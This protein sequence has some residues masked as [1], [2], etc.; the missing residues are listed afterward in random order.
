[1]CVARDAVLPRAGN[2]Y[3]QTPNHPRGWSLRSG[4]LCEGVM[5]M[6]E[7]ERR[8]GQRQHQSAAIYSFWYLGRIC[9]KGEGRHP[10]K[11][12][13]RIRG[14]EAFC[15]LPLRVSIWDRHRGRENAKA[16]E[17]VWCWARQCVRTEAFHG[18]ACHNACASVPAF[19]CYFTLKRKSLDLS[20]ILSQMP[21]FY[22]QPGRVVIWYCMLALHR[23]R[24]RK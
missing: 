19:N 8:K 22:R 16:E 14:R 2:S 23:V 9:L 20:W 17:S 12:K 3:L 5:L 24:P 6:E 1:M 15:F 21:T 11:G 13:R 7:V 4:N 10:E 18:T